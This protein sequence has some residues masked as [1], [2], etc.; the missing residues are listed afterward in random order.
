VLNRA[1]FSF[2]HTLGYSDKR[3]NIGNKKM[4]PLDLP[5]ND[6]VVDTVDADD[7]DHNEDYNLKRNRLAVLDYVEGLDDIA[8]HGGG[9]KQQEQQDEDVI[10]SPSQPPKASQTALFNLSQPGAY[11][12]IP[13]YTGTT[14]RDSTASM[15]ELMDDN[16]DRQGGAGGDDVEEAPPIE[17]HHAE[18]VQERN[19][20]EEVQ[21]KLRERTV[22]A[23]SVVASKDDDYNTK[24]AMPSP[25]RPSC[26]KKAAIVVLVALI[27][28]GVVTII[29]VLVAR[30][31]HKTASKDASPTTSTTNS[32]S[33]TA[34]ELDLEFVRN[35]LTPISGMEALTDE[36]SFQYQA[37]QWLVNEDPARL[38][39]TYNDAHHPQATTT[40]NLLV[41]RYVI[42]LLYFTTGG[43][44]Q[45]RLSLEF[46][47]ASSIC[48]WP[49]IRPGEDDDLQ[50][51]VR[52]NDNGQVKYIRLGEYTCIQLPFLGGV[53]MIDCVFCH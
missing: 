8:G 29:G 38:V 53:G 31:D 41:E 26:F 47:T 7:D 14:R 10:I 2:G 28:L 45:W 23:L 37:L 16:N 20:E 32:S 52:C 48:E 5:P 4:D 22:M 3:Y 43:P 6:G 36:S 30:S 42:A 12:V 17:F 33:P 51:G 35:L 25:P 11:A 24:T 9:D 34:T 39:S 18:I 27:C 21:I 49:A 1:L 15:A 19:L 46:L 50:L 40:T 44:H 13:N